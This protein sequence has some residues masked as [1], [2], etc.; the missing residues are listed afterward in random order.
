MKNVSLPSFYAADEN[1][2]RA[3]ELLIESG[4]GD[5]LKISQMECLVDKD[6]ECQL[7]DH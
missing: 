3:K 4:L 2:E 7:L 1:I 6:K 5:R